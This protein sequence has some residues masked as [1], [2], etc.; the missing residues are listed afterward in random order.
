MKRDNTEKGFRKTP[1]NFL[2]P[3]TRN[4][5]TILT[6]KEKEKSVQRGIRVIVKGISAQTAKGLLIRFWVRRPKS[7]TLVHKIGSSPHSIWREKSEINNQK[8]TEGEY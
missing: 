8:T 4:P 5:K 1:N 2:E 7:E 6:I 3:T